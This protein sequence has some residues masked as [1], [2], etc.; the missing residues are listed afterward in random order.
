MVNKTP[1]SFSHINWEKAVVLFQNEQFIGHPGHLLPAARD[2]LRLL[3]CAGQIGMMFAFPKA[4]SSLAP[5]IVGGQPYKRWATKKV[6]SQ[7]ERHKFVSIEYQEDGNVKVKITQAG[8]IRVI[9][10]KLDSIK[11]IPKKWDKKWRV[12]IFDIP[13]NHRHLRDQFRM[14]LKQLSMYQLQESVFVS[15]YSCFDEIEFLRE[16]YGVSFHVEYLLVEKIEHDL[17]LKEHFELVD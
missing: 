10:Y 2:V 5:L 1:D 3:A 15:P 17:K 4:A 8:M 11:I 7:L 9:N 12:V 6:L 13:N 14:R 16:L